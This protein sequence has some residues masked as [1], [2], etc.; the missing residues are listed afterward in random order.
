MTSARRQMRLTSNYSLS[1]AR[2]VAEGAS[3]VA[4]VA[5]KEALLRRRRLAE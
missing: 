3:V 4:V 1:E 5:P 2:L